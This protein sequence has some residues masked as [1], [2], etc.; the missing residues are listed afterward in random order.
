M[1]SKV[2][3][4]TLFSQLHALTQIGQFVISTGNVSKYDAK[5]KNKKRPR[6]GVLNLVVNARHPPPDL[7]LDAKEPNFLGI[8][9]R[10]V[11]DIV[12]IMERGRV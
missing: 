12:K 10:I 9:K 2:E 3:G 11:P 6:S 8:L 1:K 7:C 5:L 4:I